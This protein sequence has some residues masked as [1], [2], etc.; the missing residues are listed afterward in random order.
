[1]YKLIAINTRP[2]IR[3]RSEYS[4]DRTSCTVEFEPQ[5]ISQKKF[6]TYFSDFI[7]DARLLPPITPDE[8]LEIINDPT[9]LEK[10]LGRKDFKL[11]N[12]IVLYFG[13]WEKDL[14]NFFVLGK[15]LVDPE[16]LTEEQAPLGI[17]DTEEGMAKRYKVMDILLEYRKL[18]IDRLIIQATTTY[19]VDNGTKN[20]ILHEIDPTPQEQSTL[21]TLR[22]GAPQ[23]S[24]SSISK[25]T[26]FELRAAGINLSIRSEAPGSTARTS[27]IDVILH[28][29]EEACEEI[30][31]IANYLFYTA[32]GHIA[33][34]LMDTN[35]YP[36][37]YTLDPIMRLEIPVSSDTKRLVAHQSHISSY[38]TL[39]KYLQT[40]Y[41]SLT[42]EIGF[43]QTDIQRTLGIQETLAESIARWISDKVKIMTDLEVSHNKIT[44]ERAQLDPEADLGRRDQ[45]LYEHCLTRLSLAYLKAK[46]ATQQ[47]R[48]KSRP[49]ATEALYSEF[50]RRVE[51][52][53]ES[54]TPADMTAPIRS[55]SRPAL[56]DDEDYTYDED[57]PYDES[58]SDPEGLLA[59]QA[60]D[61][62]VLN[63]PQPE[64]SLT[65]DIFFSGEHEHN[66]EFF[67]LSW[68]TNLFKI[69]EYA[70]GAYL[71][72]QA[73]RHVVE[74]LQKRQ[75][76]TLTREDFHLS[77][78]QNIG[79][80]LEHEVEIGNISMLIKYAKYGDRVL[81]ALFGVSYSRNREPIRD[82]QNLSRMPGFCDRFGF[83]E[84]A[85][86]PSDEIDVAIYLLINDAE[87]LRL[88]KITP[89]IGIERLAR[90]NILKMFESYFPDEQIID[91]NLTAIQIEKLNKKRIELYLSILR[92][93]QLFCIKEEFH[94]TFPGRE[95]EDPTGQD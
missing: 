5:G 39:Y 50:G 40:H 38:Y 70:G 33:P 55:D 51:T 81:D 66:L 21:P 89:P 53:Y 4:Q 68:H 32:Y 59:H 60:L 47:T 34:K 91:G 2:L 29:N 49:A 84:T 14:V 76:L 87:L 77:I 52:T 93:V 23:S 71:S 64:Y 82:I 58:S 72:N 31:A 20:L 90:T 73:C 92:K 24:I 86:D 28:C 9:I 95:D 54:I 80:R 74:S 16:I 48:S 12:Q 56:L 63:P 88:K 83:L 69:L 45:L 18:I 27:D 1:M 42:S 85:I 22:R 62:L 43:Q 75:P 19:F 36:S 46:E 6:E 17:I 13:N 10:N 79:C 26:H 7:G 67:I 41:P 3:Y 61:V 44:H 35:I 8:I 15:S 78:A 11:F 30:I 25:A 94:S 65:T 57:Y 37:G